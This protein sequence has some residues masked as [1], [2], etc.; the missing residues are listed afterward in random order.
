MP[1]T[2]ITDE[3]AS[4][5]IDGEV[6]AGPVSTRFPTDGGRPR[7]RW[8]EATLFV[9]DDRTYVLH[10]VNHSLVW[11]LTESGLGHIR[12][13]VE[14]D[15]ARLPGGSVYCGS[16]TRGEQCP[17]R[18]PR[19]AAD[20]GSWPE[21]VLTEMAQ[22]KVESWPDAAAVIEGV[23]TARRRGG[24]VSVALS[25]PMRELLTEAEENDPVFR[26]AHPVMRL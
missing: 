6:I 8:M 25:E 10:T 24:A 26:S 13:P 3:F 11:H 19:W 1:V 18:G 5:E 14:T 2:R 12:K 22:H 20:P 17:Q 23:S 16:L 9:K 21:R 15:S 4:Y 7:P